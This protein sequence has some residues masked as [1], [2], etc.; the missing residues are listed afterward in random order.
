MELLATIREPAAL[1]GWITTQRVPPGVAHPPARRADRGIDAVTE[2]LG[3]DW[4]LAQERSIALHVIDDLGWFTLRP[5]SAG[6]FRLHFTT[7]NGSPVVT[8]WVSL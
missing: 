2:P 8:E 7:S 1:P 3:D 6:L 5:L 4:L